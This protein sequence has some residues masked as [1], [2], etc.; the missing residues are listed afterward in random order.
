M[1]ET[2][3]TC[4]RSGDGRAEIKEFHVIILKEVRVHAGLKARI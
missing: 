2:D 3:Q 4:D 1:W